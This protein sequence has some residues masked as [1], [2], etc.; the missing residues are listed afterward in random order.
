MTPIKS[1]T[2]QEVVDQNHQWFVVEKHPKSINASRTSCAYRGVNGTRCAIVSCAYRGVDGARCAIGCVLPD[3]LYD[4]DMDA[5]ENLGVFSLVS[6]YPSV[7]EF[8]KDIPGETLQ[9][10]QVI[11]DDYSDNSPME[12]YQYMDKELRAFAEEHHL[13]YPPQT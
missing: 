6:T 4:S 8:F 9:R 12:F 3:N 11:H 1:I 5:S 7:R 2:L 10:L 13:N